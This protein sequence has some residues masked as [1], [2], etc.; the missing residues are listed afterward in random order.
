MADYTAT[1]ISEGDHWVIDVPGVGT[2]QADSV[3]DIEEMAIDLVTAMTHTAP[4][5]RAR[6]VAHRLTRPLTSTGWAFVEGQSCRGRGPRFSESV[7]AVGGSAGPVARWNSGRLLSSQYMT[8]KSRITAAT[9]AT[10]AIWISV[11]ARPGS[12]SRNESS[13]VG[14]RR[15]ALCVVRPAWC[16]PRDHTPAR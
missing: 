2:T 8:P 9:T 3:D 14:D 15:G 13:P 10:N 12:P 5:G 11:I 1:A 16:A 4:A 6:S 7:S